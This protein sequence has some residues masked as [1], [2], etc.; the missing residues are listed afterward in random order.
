MPLPLP[1]I[2]PAPEKK[3]GKKKPAKAGAGTTSGEDGEKQ[4]EPFEVDP[5]TGLR[6]F[7]ESSHAEDKTR[8]VGDLAVRCP[9]VNCTFVQKK[10]KKARIMADHI[11]STHRPKTKRDTFS[12]STGNPDCKAS[13]WEQQKAVSHEQSCR[14]KL[15]GGYIGANR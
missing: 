7:S 15:S 11:N 10:Y 6:T 8:Y 12:C 4:A 13:F 3:K 14:K 1:D 9:D 2:A 5:T